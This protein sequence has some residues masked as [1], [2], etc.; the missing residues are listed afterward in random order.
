MGDQ[1]EL[2]IES[3]QF[4]GLLLGAL[5]GLVAAKIISPVE[6]NDPGT[7]NNFENISKEKSAIE[8]NL[9]EYAAV[10]EETELM[11]ELENRIVNYGVIIVAGL[12]AFQ[13]L[14]TAQIILL[15]IASMLFSALT[16]ALAE[17]EVKIHDMGNYLR[18]DLFPRI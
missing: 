16:W 3:P 11:I 1:R 13:E 17:A 6:S 9:A 15:L 4:G 7:D 14:F 8:V 18:N 10:R 2:G 5:I 12:F